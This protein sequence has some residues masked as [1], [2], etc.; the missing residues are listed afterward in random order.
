MLVD[1]SDTDVFV[2]LVYHLHKTWTLQKLY[3]KRGTSKTKKTVPVHQLI[4]QLDSKLVSCLVAIHA[5]SGC[6]STSKVGPKLAGLK[7]S[8]DLSLLQE[9]GVAV[10]SQQMINNAEMFLVSTLK[11]SDCSTFDEYRWEQ[12]HNSKL[13]LDFNQL[14][15]C[16]STIQEHIKR[17][18]LQCKMWLQAP[19]PASTNPD[20]LEYGYEE[21]EDGIRPVILP[22]PC[23]PEDLP[24]ACK[25]PT[26]CMSVKTCTCRGKNIK[27]VTFC[28]YVKAKCRNPT[29]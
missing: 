1:S 20:P 8:M 7:V 5:L 16:S 19:T 25:C 9:F 23:R 29:K 11:K 10:L 14:V 3:V 24:P 21:T 27:C 26:S 12:Y 6:D 15:C 28:A 22:V 17:A 2:N 4:E 18:Y 13:E